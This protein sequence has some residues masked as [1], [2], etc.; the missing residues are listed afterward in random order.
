MTDVIINWVR[1]G[2]IDVLVL[3]MIIVTYNKVY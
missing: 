1:K 3:L 2:N